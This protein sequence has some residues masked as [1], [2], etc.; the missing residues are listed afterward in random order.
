MEESNVLT[1][2]DSIPNNTAPNGRVFH[3]VCLNDRVMFRVDYADKKGGVLPSELEGLWT[4]ATLAESFLRNYLVKMWD[5]SD[6][7]AQRSAR[8]EYKHRVSADEENGKPTSETT[9][10]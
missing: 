7:S 5:I 2:E 9:G 8:R 6:R 1:R 4:K 10:S 3:V